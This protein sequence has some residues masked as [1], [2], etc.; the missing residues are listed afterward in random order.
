MIKKIVSIF[1]T[2]IIMVFLMINKPTQKLFK[3]LVNVTK[4]ITIGGLIVI[5]VSAV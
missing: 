1:N 4:Y 2:L 5:L 3:V